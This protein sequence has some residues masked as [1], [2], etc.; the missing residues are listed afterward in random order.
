MHDSIG[1]KLAVLSVSVGTLQG[2]I[3]VSAAD[4]EAMLGDFLALIKHARKTISRRTTRDI[5]PLLDG[6]QLAQAIEICIVTLARLDSMKGVFAITGDQLEGSHRTT[7]PGERLTR[8]ERD[9]TRLIAGGRTNKD[10]AREL[11]CSV[12][13]IDAHRANLMRKLNLHSVSAL[14]L[15]A[16]RNKIVRI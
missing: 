12:K 9:V 2:A 3:G 4:A 7:P 16:V 6:L 5:F 1:R 13:T 14:V 15:Y 10:V 8:R 11:L